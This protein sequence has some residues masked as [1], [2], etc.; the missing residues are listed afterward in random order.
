LRWHEDEAETKDWRNPVDKVKAPIVP[1]EPLEPVR[2][3]TIK[4]MM[5]TCRP[6]LPNDLG[7]TAAL[8]LLLDTGIRLA[9]FLALNLND[10]NQFSGTIVIR[11]G[12]GRSH[13]TFTWAKGRAKLFEDT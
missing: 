8:L 11:S 9:E 12:K 2:I 7:G 1:L 10:V 6:G 5:E 3:D 13:A 4:A